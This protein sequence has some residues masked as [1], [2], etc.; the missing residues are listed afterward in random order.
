MTAAVNGERIVT[1]CVLMPVTMKVDAARDSDGQVI[2]IGARSFGGLPSARE[3]E[4]SMDADGFA[5]LDDAYE[6]ADPA[7]AAA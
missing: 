2:I 1:I 3:I 5:A 6:A 7:K 4:E